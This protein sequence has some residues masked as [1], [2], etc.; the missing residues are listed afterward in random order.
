[1]FYC[2]LALLVQIGRK[3]SKPRKARLHSLRV[4]SL[5]MA[6]YCRAALLWAELATAM[7]WIGY[8]DGLQFLLGCNVYWVAMST[9]FVLATGGLYSLLLE[10]ACSLL[11]V[12]VACWK[13]EW[14]AGIASAFLVGYRTHCHGAYPTGLQLVAHGL[15]NGIRTWCV[16]I[17]AIWPGRQQPPGSLSA[18]CFAMALLSL[19]SGFVTYYIDRGCVACWQAT[20]YVP[21]W[22]AAWPIEGQLGLL[23][24]YSYW[25]GHSFR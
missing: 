8:R 14:S 11:A 3:G 6:Y 4:W 2:S 17:C 19:M 25:Q 21:Y 7:G 10:S 16:C 18:L 9:G 12:S 15:C 22:Q 23:V 5:H 20:V 13:G 24:G 1:M